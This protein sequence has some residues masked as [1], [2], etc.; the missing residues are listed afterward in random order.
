MMK[1][2]RIQV[3]GDISCGSEKNR[4]KS[5]LVEKTV[6]N[7]SYRAS[8]Q[9]IAW[10]GLLL[11]RDIPMKRSIVLNGLA[12]SAMLLGFQQMAYADACTDAWNASSASETC[13]NKDKVNNG[14]TITDLGNGQCR[15]Q[16]FCSTDVADN[17]NPTDI[18]VN[19]A[20][21]PTLNNCYGIVRGY[22]CN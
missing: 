19:L 7:D 5:K 4:C 20:D 9:L 18:T 6:I 14:I 2:R 8:E 3:V 22:A 16:T 10:N 11:T 21:V 17:S 1:V 12:L 15:I 13:P